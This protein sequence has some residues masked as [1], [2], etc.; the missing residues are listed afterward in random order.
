LP[1]SLTRG[2]LGA[3]ATHFLLSA[4]ILC[5]LNG[6]RGMNRVNTGAG[7]LTQ[8]PGEETGFE[9]SEDIKGRDDVG[10]TRNSVQGGSD[11]LD[12]LATTSILGGF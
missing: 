8:A 7:K 1:T 2:V 4:G 10:R 5:R 11:G 9:V 12:V 3:L 6:V